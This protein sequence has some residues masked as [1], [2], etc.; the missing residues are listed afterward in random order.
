MNE[1]LNKQPASLASRLGVNEKANQPLD[2]AGRRFRRSRGSGRHPLYAIWC[3][4]KARCFNPNTR[5][6]TWYGAR[7]ITMHPAW[8]I[9]F[10]VFL[11]D[12]PSKPG[13]RYWLDRIDNDGPYAPGNI[14][15]ATPTQQANNRRHRALGLIR[16]DSIP[17]G[18]TNLKE[19]C[20]RARVSYHGV[21]ARI[22][23]T[24]C[25]PLLAIGH[26][27]LR[28]RLGLAPHTRLGVSP[29]VR[30]RLINDLTLPEAC[31]RAAVN[32][33]SV[34]SLVNSARALKKPL[35]ISPLK[36]CEEQTP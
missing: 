17:A 23:A 10:Q 31:R 2:L 12:L 5:E 36:L 15:W 32:Y 28:R 18:D 13:P 21:Y 24:G 19:S 9:S 7:G 11:A 34:Y 26:F 14:R 30:R 33:H 16:P 29:H 3:A 27:A 35:P 1:E 22:K 4:I 8:R 6:Y 20:R 25:T